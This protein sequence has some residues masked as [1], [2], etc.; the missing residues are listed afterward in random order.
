MW[1]LW[2][3]KTKIMF[4]RISLYLYQ[5][6]SKDVCRGE[7]GH[8]FSGPTVTFT[9]ENCRCEHRQTTENGRECGGSE[10]IKNKKIKS[11]KD[12]LVAHR[13]SQA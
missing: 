4:K 5:K 11:E 7:I 3:T 12:N 8:H 10:K 2:R 1:V 6:L 9:F 13:C